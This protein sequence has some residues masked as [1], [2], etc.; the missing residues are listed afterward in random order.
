MHGLQKNVL[1]ELSERHII[2]TKQGV[3]FT[4]VIIVTLVLVETNYE[5]DQCTDRVHCNI[6]RL[7]H[8]Q[9][10][11]HMEIRCLNPQYVDV[12]CVVRYLLV[13][14]CVALRHTMDIFVIIINVAC[15]VI[16][17]QMHLDL[18]GRIFC[19]FKVSADPDEITK[20]YVNSY[21]CHNM[22]QL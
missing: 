6:G 10:P 18:R 16:D 8:L 15:A 22:Y 12:L 2:K 14:V 9:M 4:N 21:H 1:H 5:C 11:I 7:H 17:G 20:F 3:V 19:H 13:V